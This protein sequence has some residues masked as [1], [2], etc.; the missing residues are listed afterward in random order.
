MTTPYAAWRALRGSRSR[1]GGQ[2]SE[3]GGE[4]LLGVADH[5]YADGAQRGVGGDDEEAR[6]WS[7][8]D[9]SA[10]PLGYDV[11]NH[12]PEGAVRYIEV[13]GHAGTGAVEISAN[14][15]LKA[16][17]LGAEHWLYIVTEALSAPAL[18]VVRDPAHRLP[19]EEI[20]ERVRYRV[21]QT[22]WRQVAERTDFY[23]T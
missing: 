12:G 21:G 14:E 23:E 19:R 15:W 2:G 1:E 7:V 17:Q 22:G 16:E 11:L 10:Q 18:H 13:K 8:D 4:A 5:R 9:V 20:V 3:R 6:G